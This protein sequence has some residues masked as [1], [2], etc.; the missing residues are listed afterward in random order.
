LRSR[1]ARWWA[2]RAKKET[3]VLEVTKVRLEQLGQ[4]VRKVIEV[5]RVNEDRKDNAA[6]R[7][8]KAKRETKEI[9]E[10]EA[11]KG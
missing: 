1:V 4:R 11:S 8:Y 2:K 3:P 5:R 6:L 10:K 9:K 7:E